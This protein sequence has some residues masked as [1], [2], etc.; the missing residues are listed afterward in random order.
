MRSLDLPDKTL[1]FIRDRPLMDDA[2]RPITGKPLLLKRGPLLTRL[3]VDDVTASDGQSYPVMFIGTGE[4][5]VRLQGRTVFYCQLRGCVYKQSFTRMLI[6]L[7][8]EPF[9]LQPIEFVVLTLKSCIQIMFL[10]CCPSEN[11]YV[12]K[13]VNYDGEMH[14]IEEVKLFENAEPID[15]LRLHQNQVC[16]FGTDLV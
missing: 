5:P 9:K 13:A 1:Q 4:T 16:K 7:W 15:V 3:V 2:V 6:V 11:G 14:I 10:Y 12:Q 8:T